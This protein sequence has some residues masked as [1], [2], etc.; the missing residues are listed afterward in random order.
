[1]SKKLRLLNEL[2]NKYLNKKISSVSFSK[3]F[4]TV[5]M[6]DNLRFDSHETGYFYIFDDLFG[7]IEFFE[8]NVRKRKEY[9]MLIGE[10][11]LLAAVK[12]AKR[13]LKSLKKK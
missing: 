6:N 7:Y 10:K 3:K 5:Y 2:I 9:E 8:P 11:E 13:K 1:M 4:N 12:E